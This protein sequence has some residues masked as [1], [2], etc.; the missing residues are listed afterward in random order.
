MSK[1]AL[2]TEPVQH[3]D[4]DEG[5]V[6]DADQRAAGAQVADGQ[7]ERK[8]TPIVDSSEPNV[9][10]KVDLATA[11]S[12]SA[13]HSAQ[14]VQIEQKLQTDE[15]RRKKLLAKRGEIDVLDDNALDAYHAELG[16]INLRI[17]TLRAARDLARDRAKRMQSVELIE[18]FEQ[19]AR[20]ETAEL[21]KK[22][23][24]GLVRLSALCHE[25]GDLG[26]QLDENVKAISLHNWESERLGRR[27]LAIDP[28]A[29]RA[30]TL[31]ALGKA[32][33]VP[34]EE[35]LRNGEGD[36]E[37]GQRVIAELISRATAKRAAGEKP[38]AFAVRTAAA[39]R[40]Y[41]EREDAEEEQRYLSRLWQNVAEKLPCPRLPDEDEHQFA[42]RLRNALARALHLSRVG[43]SDDAFRLRQ[44]RAYAKLDQARQKDDPLLAAAKRA[45]KALENH[46]APPHVIEQAKRRRAR[47]REAGQ[48]AAPEPNWNESPFAQWLA[49]KAAAGS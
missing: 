48:P 37:F 24:A 20:S 23:E 29:V 35:V 19:R 33:S 13:E 34:I 49:L 43:E 28:S 6:S 14:A 1:N 30:A 2:R 47:I 9:P 38:R 4:D 40:V 39:K 26:L 16:R 7:P 41:V 11:M 5:F 25:I 22:R 8:H 45:V 31:K 36:G 44:L 18:E 32:D 17:D 3:E 21:R 15:E 12:S 10:R 42:A 27:D 46:A